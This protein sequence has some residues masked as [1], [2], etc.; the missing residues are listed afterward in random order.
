M[1][2]AAAADSHVGGQARRHLGDGDLVLAIYGTVPRA[3][4]WEITTPDWVP[5]QRST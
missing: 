5:E 4:I 2:M 3:L 1:M